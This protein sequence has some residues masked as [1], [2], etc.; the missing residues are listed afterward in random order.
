MFKGIIDF[1]KHEI[2]LNKEY[3]QS[4]EPSE[5]VLAS[6]G[7]NDEIEMTYQ[8]LTF[9]VPK[10]ITNEEYQR[11]RK[12]EEAWLEAHYDL[13][14]VQGIQSIPERSDLPRPP[15]ADSDGFRNYTCDIDYYLR[16]KSAEFEKK[17]NAELAILCLRKSNAIRMVSRRGYRKDDYYALVRLLA[18]YGFT[19]DAKVEKDKLD[20]FFGAND[21]DALIADIGSRVTDQIRGDA[22]RMGTDL[23]IMSVHG[24]SCPDCARY[25]GRVFS[26]TG[27]DKRFPRLPPE[28]S[29]YGGVHPGC[30][31]TFSPYIHGVNDPML[32]YTLTLQNN[33]AQ[34]YRKDIVAFSNRPFID[35]RLPADIEKA[36]EHAAKLEAERQQQQ[37]YHAHMIEIE[38]QR[39]ID[40]RDYKWLQ[41]NLPDICPKSYSG[42]KRMKNGKTKNYQ[43]I[44]AK[45]K[46]LGR[47]IS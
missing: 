4:L 10:P 3:Y 37:Y 25:Q 42:Y 1:F 30:G 9:K 24:A 36:K 31:H 18:R 19:E 7:E 14:S 41:E 11:K 16:F 5:A 32:E 38:A 35:D 46:A 8:G 40:K 17:G 45:A 12:A 20:E 28:I 33:V 39:G 34:R 15:N 13:N 26:L 22:K 23:V 43:K 27:R 44:V 47:S 29:L 21:N 2:Q 6:N